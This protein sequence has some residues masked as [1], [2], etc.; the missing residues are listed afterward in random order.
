MKKVEN[1]WLHHCTA[2]NDRVIGN[3]RSLKTQNDESLAIGDAKEEC[4]RKRERDLDGRTNE[5]TNDEWTNEQKIWKS[6]I[7]VK[8]KMGNP[9]KTY[10]QPYCDISSWPEY[11]K[12]LWCAYKENSKCST[13][14]SHLELSTRC[15]CMILS[16]I[17]RSSWNSH[18]CW[19]KCSTHSVASGIQGIKWMKFEGKMHTW[20][21]WKSE[22]TK[23]TLESNTKFLWA[24]RYLFANSWAA[25]LTFWATLNE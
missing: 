1:G 23:K 7:K 6:A 4:K 20:T 19:N 25:V 14:D 22:N 8:I 21:I 13:C 17:V 24:L 12:H 2:Y 10:C 5:R 15:L 3:E 16:S 18:L 11:P 9:N